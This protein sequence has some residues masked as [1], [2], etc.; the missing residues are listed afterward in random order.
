[1][2]K[3]RWILFAAAGVAGNRGLNRR[4]GPCD[5]ATGACAWLTGIVPCSTNVPCACSVFQNAGPSIIEACIECKLS[6]N[7][8]TQASDIYEIAAG[9]GL[10]GTQTSFVTASPTTFPTT[11]SVQA[12]TITSSATTTSGN[13]ILESRLRLVSGGLPSS[14]HT[15]AIV[16]GVV[17]G[18]VVLVGLALGLGFYYRRIKPAPSGISTTDDAPEPSAIRYPETEYPTPKTEIAGAIQNPETEAVAQNTEIS[19]GRL[20][21]EST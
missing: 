19:G 17:A 3:M 7:A 6:V 5:A 13:T 20:K 9:C 16:G 21:D 14:S 11:P 4:V 15:G 8:L 1:M 2:R 18:F 12:V 10:E